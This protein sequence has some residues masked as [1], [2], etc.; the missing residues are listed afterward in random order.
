MASESP[1]VV[2]SPRV[3]DTLG[4]E[5]DGVHPSAHELADRDFLYET[6]RDDCSLSIVVKELDF[7]GS[8]DLHD[9]ILTKLDS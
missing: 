5:H 8:L 7:F 3:G 9:V 4:S 2:A 6:L 1:I